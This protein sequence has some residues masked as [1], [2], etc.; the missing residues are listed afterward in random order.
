MGHR[1]GRRHTHSGMGRRAEWELGG[2]QAVGLG[3]W[4]CRRV[5]TAP[6]ALEGVLS[7]FSPQLLPTQAVSTFQLPHSLVVPLMGRP[8]LFRS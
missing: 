6:S 5:L 3:P 8:P 4:S 1:D 2:E 7:G